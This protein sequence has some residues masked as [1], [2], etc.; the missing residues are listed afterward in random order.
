M[1]FDFG[2]IPSKSS[3]VIRLSELHSALTLWIFAIGY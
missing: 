3:Y 1:I 2:I